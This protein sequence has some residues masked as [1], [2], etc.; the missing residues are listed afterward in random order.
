RLIATVCVKSLTA[1]A[2]IDP[3]LNANT[4]TN[5]CTCIVFLLFALMVTISLS[6][7]CHGLICICFLFSFRLFNVSSTI[8][9][10]YG[11]VKRLLLMLKSSLFKGNN[12]FVK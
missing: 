4:P 1:H 11:L 8:L 6:A 9:Y 5:T 10:V 3:N 7:M 2:D 12:E